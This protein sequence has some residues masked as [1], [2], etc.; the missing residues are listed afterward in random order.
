[1]VSAEQAVRAELVDRVVA[2]FDGAED[3]RLKELMEALTRHLHAFMREVRLT[4][5]EW[6]RAIEFLTE[7]GHITDD[8]RQEFILLSDVLG[9]SMQTITI[10]NEAYADATEAT[11]FGPFFV[12]GSPEIEIG[13]DIA[14]GAPGE[15]CWV[16]GTVTDTDGNPLPG[17]ADR[18]VGGRRGRPLR[19]AVRR[20]PD[21]GPRAPVHRRR[22]AA[23]GS[24]RS[25]PRRTRS[26]TTVRSA[27][28]WRASA[29][30]RCAPRTCTS[31]S[32]DGRPDAGDPH[33]PPRGRLLDATASS[34]SRTRWSR[35]SSPRPPAPRPP[36]AGTLAA[37]WSRVRFDIVLAPP[38]PRQLER[39]AEAGRRRTAQA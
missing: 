11:V 23:T 17:R 5:E 7:A 28:C 32:G 22:A 19:R 4:E 33:L 34:A 13:G 14:V 25:P 37:T 31:W 1:M 26:R 27:S 2:S 3:P 35:T 18:G 9:A 8:R 15:P 16:E 20:R 12:E 21:A 10:N 39:V 29:A 38:Q 24:G 36:T 6:E 30:P